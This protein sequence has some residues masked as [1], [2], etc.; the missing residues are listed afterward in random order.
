MSAI[1][2]GHG[3]DSIDPVAAAAEWDTTFVL[4]RL[5]EV[6]PAYRYFKAGNSRAGGVAPVE[7]LGDGALFYGALLQSEL[8][9]PFGPAAPAAATRP[10]AGG[11][12][13]GG[14]RQRRAMQVRLAYG[15]E[16][17]RLVNMAHAAVGDTL[18]NYVGNFPNYGDGAAYWSINRND[19]GSLPLITFALNHGLLGWGLV[20]MAAANVGFYMDTWINASGFI[21]QDKNAGWMYGCPLGFPDGLADFG[22]LLHLWTATARADANQG[23]GWAAENLPKAVKLANFTLG[24][25]RNASVHTA[26]GPTKGLIWGPAE[27]DTCHSPGYYFSTNMWAWRGMLEFGTLL[28]AG[29]AGGQQRAVGHALVVEAALFHADIRAALDVAVV[30]NTTTGAIYFVPPLAGADQIPFGTMIESTL[31]SYSGFRYFSEML[32]SGFMSDGEAAALSVFR[33]SHEGTLSGMT[34]YTDH[35]DDMPAVGYAI[36]DAMLDR[37][38]NFNLLMF[39]H[40]ANCKDPAHAADWP[41]RPDSRAIAGFPLPAALG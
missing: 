23:G 21:Q 37:R 13:D 3:C 35:L 38:D 29:G 28:A 11:G 22:Q 41:C 1:A 14:S 36:S 27:H 12:I 4:V 34:R 15:A 33:E 17:Q 40:A 2:A 32:S 31:A 18:D 30:R 26:D 10:G 20:D 39:G 25:R 9:S 7:L 24:L 16:G 5:S 8:G 6:W 19:N